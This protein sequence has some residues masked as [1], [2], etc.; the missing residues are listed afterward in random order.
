MRSSIYIEG[1]EGEK[2]LIDIGPEFRIQALRAKIKRLD[3]VFLTHS[4]AD[5]VHGLDDIRPLSFKESMP[6]Y[7]NSNTLND[8]KERFSYVFKETQKGGGKPHISP[9]VAE[10]P[11]SI[12]KLTFTPIPVMH[13]VL[14]ILAWKISEGEFSLLYLTDT[15]LIPP[16]SFNLIKKVD[17]AIIG[18]LR[19][20]IHETHF[21]FD[22]AFSAAVA[23]NARETYLTHIC[24][25]HSHKEIEEICDSFR[26]EHGIE[27]LIKPLHDEQILYLND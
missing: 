25:D 15:K 17:I 19:A 24:H 13:G 4:H 1:K 3:A 18:A 12:G 2:A 20:R 5:H 21:N 9:F 26:K 14:D 27:S 7:A 23:I 11:V 8:L 10:S 16:A 6:I 22:E